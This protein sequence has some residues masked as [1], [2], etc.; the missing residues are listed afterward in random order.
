MNTNNHTYAAI[1]TAMGL[2]PSAVHNWAKRG[3]PAAKVS[4]FKEVIASLPKRTTMLE[5]IRHLNDAGLT[6]KDLARI[7]RVSD[8]TVRRW[9]GQEFLPVD[10]EQKCLSVL[11]PVEVSQDEALYAYRKVSRLVD[12]ERQM[13]KL[14][15]SLRTTLNRLR[16]ESEITA[17]KIDILEAEARLSEVREQLQ[18]ARQYID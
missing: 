12:E 9:F 7:A 10:Q 15:L 14:V 8:A 16:E 5:V 6:K 4:L 18:E 3:I 1:S 13:Q 11:A 17:T 2:C